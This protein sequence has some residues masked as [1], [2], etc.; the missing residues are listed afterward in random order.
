MTDSPARIIS[1]A[2]NLT[3]TLFA[4]GLG[5]RLVGATEHS[6]YPP[7]AKALPR[8]GSYVGLNLEAILA[9][10]PDLVLATADGNDPRDVERLTA[11]GVPVF[12]TRSGDVDGV[13]AG[14]ERIAAVCGAGERGT[15]LADGLR[16]RIQRVGE[17]VA[18][19]KRPLVFLQVNLQ[20]IIS[21]NRDSYLHDLL[22][23]AGGRNLAADA[24]STYPRYSLEEIV[25][26]SPEVILISSMTRGGDFAA[27]RQ[28]WM[29]WTSIPAVAGGRVH[30]ID[31]DLVDRPSP[32][33][34]DGLE[35]L[36]R[37]LHPD[38][39]WGS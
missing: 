13:L 16:E 33:L 21:A 32:R 11:L 17:A 38:A 30:L 26:R 3:E 36:A 2:P 14:I 39:D 7:A 8:V 4:L 1:L 35:Q 27:A 24:A 6:D 23:L 29:R 22:R 34:V 5:K 28:A 15:A 12:V 37:L 10:S 20:P 25:R 31:S 18:G 19:R 9:L